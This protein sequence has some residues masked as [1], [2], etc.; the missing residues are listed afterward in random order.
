[1]AKVSAI[2]ENLFAYAEAC[3][4]GA[5]RC[6]AA[7]AAAF[8]TDRD[9]GTVRAFQ[10]AGGPAAAVPSKPISASEQAVN[11]AFQRLQPLWDQD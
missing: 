1:M 3:T 8:C 7:L 2:P 11:A 4:R 10:E 6:R 9:V 5:E